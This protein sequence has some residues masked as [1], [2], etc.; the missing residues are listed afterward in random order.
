MRVDH[1]TGS[2]LSGPL[3][4]I[5]AQVKPEDALR[6]DVTFMAVERVS[7]GKIDPLASSARLILSTRGAVPVRAGTRMTRAAGFASGES[8][9]RFE[10]I[11]NGAGL[12]RTSL[13]G[14]LESALPPGA[15]VV[16]EATDGF[17]TQPTSAPAAGLA[18]G[19][20]RLAVDL[21]SPPSPPGGA[22]GDASIQLCI[23]LEDYSTPDPGAGVD[24]GDD[25]SLAATSSR[26]PTLQQ[27][28]VI[29]DPKTVKGPLHLAVMVPF[30]FRGQANEGLVA[31]VHVA[32]GSAKDLSHVKACAVAS[33]D[34]QRSYVRVT[35][36]H[37]ASPD[38]STLYAALEGM[39]QPGSRR[40]ATVFLSGW[41]GARICEDVALSADDATLAKL[42]QDMVAA[43][44]GGPSDKR[45]VAWQMDRAAL[46][47]LAKLQ[48]D[49]Q[50]PPELSAVLADQAGEAGRHSSSMDEVLENLQNPED[51]TR[52]L[53]ATNLQYLADNSP[54]SRARAFD[55]LKSRELAPPG[56]D[57]FG[58]ARER[59]A[60][61]EKAATR[62]S[63]PQP[64]GA[65]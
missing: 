23:V 28:T 61:L 3:A 20:R 59:R 44:G 5:P 29:L 6:V 60:A 11:V 31:I 57:P 14:Q 43:I 58:G 41:S 32:A 21:Y 1:Y 37:A 49:N 16:F 46:A 19:R 47:L 18:T 62:P 53:V 42:A 2:P 56:Y 64:G 52:R 4:N 15:T 34:L 13:L 48:A 55:W 36:Q 33:A 45:N 51:L 22:L 39:L 63:T 26:S 38:E 35:A 54:G 30:R 7:P 24:A 65:P 9:D 8:A 50:L 17:T 25:D 12:G 27:E 10:G 40:S